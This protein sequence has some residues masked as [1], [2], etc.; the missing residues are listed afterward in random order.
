MA[1]LDTDGGDA[2]IIAEREFK[3]VSFLNLGELNSNRERFLVLDAPYLREPVKNSGHINLTTHCFKKPK[4]TIKA[5]VEVSELGI[6]P[7]ETIRV[8]INL[9]NTLKKRRFAKKNQK[10][11]LL[12]LCQQLDFRSQSTVNPTIF[13]QKSLTIAVH[14]QGTCKSTPGAGPETRFVEFD[15]PEN[16]PPTSVKG[17]DLIT[18]SYFFRLDMQSFDVIVP[19]IL[20]SSKSFGD[21]VFH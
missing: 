5:E 2:Q 14:S 8:Q 6:L 12:S 13:A 4:G 3:V 20:G 15:V 11:V 10:C 18:C 19:V 16:L 1:S 21:E 7:G 9:D 17:N